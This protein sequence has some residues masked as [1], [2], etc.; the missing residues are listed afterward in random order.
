MPA[1]KENET[2]ENQ[3][4]I[5]L[6]NEE[7]ENT[8]SENQEVK[9]ERLNNT[10]KVNFL[11]TTPSA[12]TP[13]WDIIGR[14]TTSKENNYGAKVS[15]EHWIIEENE[16]HSLDGYSLGSDIEQVALKGDPVFDYID[17][18]MYRMKKGTEA[19]TE[20]LEVYKYKVDETGATPKYKARKFK[21]LIVPDTDNLEGGQA[22][23]IKYKIQVLGDPT[24]GTV[25][26][27]NGVPTFA[28]ETASN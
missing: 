22:Y 27:T 18:L 20:K 5:N 19:E 4:E 25:T 13:K 9:L 26:F 1:S 7:E 28:Q 2:E 21:V 8:V 12:T 15:D 3:E 17:E 11:N 23:K 10:A 24:F 14:G 6:L 16:R